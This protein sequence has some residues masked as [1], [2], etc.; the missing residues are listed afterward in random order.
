MQ[1]HCTQACAACISLQNTITEIKFLRRLS[2]AIHTQF[3]QKAKGTAGEAFATSCVHIDQPTD[4][5]YLNCAFNK[6]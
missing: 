5:S 2:A 6:N 4:I 1:C 3:T